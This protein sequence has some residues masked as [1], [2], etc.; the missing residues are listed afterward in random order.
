MREEKHVRADLGALPCLGQVN[1]TSLREVSG[2]RIQ[3]TQAYPKQ[4]SGVKISAQQT[5]SFLS[6]LDST[7]NAPPYRLFE[8]LET[9][10]RG[11]SP[12]A[13]SNTCHPSCC[14]FRP[15]VPS[16]TG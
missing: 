5:E 9:Y 10:W 14:S 6:C 13:A 2:T 12:V 16:S 3:P 15:F 11:M 8:Y 7:A 1:H 4:S